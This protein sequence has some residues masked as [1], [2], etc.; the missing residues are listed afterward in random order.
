MV[1]L[2]IILF[3]DRG[4]SKSLKQSSQKDDFFKFTEL[5]SRTELTFP[6]EEKRKGKIK[7]QQGASI[8]FRGIDFKYFSTFPATEFSFFQQ[9][10]NES[11][12]FETLEASFEK[13]ENKRTGLSFNGN[14]FFKEK[15]PIILKAG[16]LSYSKSISQLKSPSFS[17]AS[18][19]IKNGFGNSFGLGA[20]L[21]NLNSSGKPES[22]ALY[23]SPDN[24]IFEAA[25]FSS[26]DFLYSIGRSFKIGKN[27]DYSTRFS[28]GRFFLSEKKETTWF[29][30]TRR[31]SSGW[32]DAFVWENSI[33]I[34][35]GKFQ[36]SF[37]IHQSPFE[38][39]RFWIKNENRTIAGPI[40]LEADFF[41]ADRF[42]CKNLKEGFY[43]AKSS[44]EP[45]VFQAKINP[46]Y[47]HTFNTPHLV[48][49]AGIS[50]MFEKKQEELNPVKEFSQFH[51][52]SAVQISTKK[53][54]VK[55]S[56]KITNIPYKR[57]EYAVFEDLKYSA[58]FELSHSFCSWKASAKNSYS[59]TEE[60][61]GNK[62]TQDIS[63]LAYFPNRILSSVSFSAGTTKSSD[64]EDR[65]V[66]I[67]TVLKSSK[68]KIRVSGS[69]KM[70]YKW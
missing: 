29:C 41:A 39:Y 52:G 28:G 20:S 13:I 27:Y 66:Q 8:V 49:S 59:V 12:F 67:G 55:T 30:K 45:V 15:V 58:G 18:S 64:K 19:A 50:G 1:L 51:T 21:P 32:Y 46:Q 2:F 48:F 11:G 68:G 34:P 9:S 35:V 25:C 4:F 63:F 22:L 44:P 6:K 54:T 57:S 69:V 56:A 23:F 33:S 36:F 37:G 42:F 70:I 62:K 53:T 17:T 38:N 61:K 16:N 5:S 10:Y 3:V 60:K 47:R 31:F 65:T 40:L 7:N 26:S 14:K 24:W 43:T